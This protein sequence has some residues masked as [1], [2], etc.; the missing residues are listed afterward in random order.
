MSNQVSNI[1][2]PLNIPD[3]L[4][5]VFGYLPTACLAKLTYVNKMW[6]L[7][8]RHKLYQ[9]RSK[10][11]YRSI[12]G[13]RVSSASDIVR[14]YLDILRQNGGLDAFHQHHIA[15]FTKSLIKVSKFLSAF[16][17]NH[18]SELF[19]IRDQLQDQWN[20]AK[21]EYAGKRKASKQAY[22]IFHMDPGN[23]DKYNNYRETKQ[24]LKYYD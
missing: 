21:A 16:N 18:I 17:L 4:A 1:R 22:K 6:R 5:N 11:I 10:I 13:C 15:D 2:N 3:I 23:K 7:E 24:E 14:L 8:A 20:G 9:N 19:L 12:A